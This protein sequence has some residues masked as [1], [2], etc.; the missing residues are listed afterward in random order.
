MKKYLTA[1]A[2]SLI[3]L[4]GIAAAADTIAQQHTHR[5]EHHREIKKGELPYGLQQ[6][7]LSNKQKIQ[8][9][10]II[11]NSRTR[12]VKDTLPQQARRAEFVQKI[13]ARHAAEQTLISSKTFN[14]T[15]ARKLIAERQSQQDQNAAERRKRNADK[16]IKRLKLQHDIFQTLTPAQQQKWLNDQKQRLE[17]RFDRMQRQNGQTKTK[18][19]K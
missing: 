5:S 2:A 16:E 19:E 14:E 8:I 7:N 13:K 3:G 10:K 12:P 15:A 1:A 17:K 6:L 18:E 11:D 4:A 9:Q